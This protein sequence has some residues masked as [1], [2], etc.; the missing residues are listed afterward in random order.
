MTVDEQAVGAEDFR[1]PCGCY[2]GM[3]DGKWR[4]LDVFFLCQRGH[5]S[6][7]EMTDVVDEK[8]ERS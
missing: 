2:V 5:K 3:F 1:L 8:E 4:I 7:D 6:L